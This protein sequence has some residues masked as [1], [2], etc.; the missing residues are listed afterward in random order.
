MSALLPL[1][2]FPG[3]ASLLAAI[4]AAVCLRDPQAITRAV[5]RVLTVAIADPGIVL[6]PCVQRPLPGRYARRELHRSATLGYS[7]VAMCWGPG[8][9][10]PLHDHDALWRVEGV[11]QGTLQVTPYALL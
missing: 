5:Q 7:V 6:P 11:W 4:D 8:Q 1:L 3:R 9:G 2:S 10:T